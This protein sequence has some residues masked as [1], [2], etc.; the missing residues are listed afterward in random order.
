MAAISHHR[1]GQIDW[2]THVFDAGSAARAELRTLHDAGIQLR[3]AVCIQARADAGVQQG[4]ILHVANRGD[5]GGQRPGAN[6]C[7][8]KLER[9]LDGCLAKRALSGRY[10][11]RAAM[12]DERRGSQGLSSALLGDAAI[13]D[14]TLDVPPIGDEHHAPAVFGAV[15]ASTLTDAA[16]GA[17]TPR[18][19]SPF[20][21]ALD[22][23]F[24]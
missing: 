17:G 12:D 14:S 23:V 2:M 1:Y 8:A 3:L 13:H 6:L 5:C 22:S 24:T 20:L 18:Q 10:R 4:L 9:T 19:R 7:P 15:G 21:A 16:F 11:T